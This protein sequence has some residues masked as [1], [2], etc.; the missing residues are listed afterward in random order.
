M[1]LDTTN[2]KLFNASLKAAFKARGV[3]VK[4]RIINSYN[5]PRCWVEVLRRDGKVFS[6]K[7]R[8]AVFDAN[9]LKRENLI[10]ETDVSYGNIRPHMIATHVPFWVKVFEGELGFDLS[11]EIKK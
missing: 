9:G 10:D 6:N 8:L 4:A 3:T 7:L 2:A 11:E 1:N 5:F